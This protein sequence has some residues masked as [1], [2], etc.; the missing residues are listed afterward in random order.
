[1]ATLDRMLFIFGDR[2]FQ[3]LS[4]ATASDLSVGTGISIQVLTCMVNTALTEPSPQLAPVL[5]PT[6]LDNFIEVQM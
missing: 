6:M 3:C 4:L 1:M 2:V 5:P